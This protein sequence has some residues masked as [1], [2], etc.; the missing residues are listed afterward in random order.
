ML[1]VCAASARAEGLAERE[2][3]IA[4][5]SAR[6]EPASVLPRNDLLAMAMRRIAR[7]L[8]ENEGRVSLL[9]DF[10]DEPEAAARLDRLARMMEFA[11]AQ[12]PGTPMP[13]E[14][15][16]TARAITAFME[17]APEDSRLCLRFPGMK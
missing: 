7:S 17:A 4:A 8:A 14:V 1:A 13:A 16:A 6:F 9:G 12:P 15:E 2:K 3:A 10:I 11:L 5:L